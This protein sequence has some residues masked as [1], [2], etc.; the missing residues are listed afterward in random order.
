LAPVE[1]IKL[2]RGGIGRRPLDRGRARPGL[3]LFAPQNGGGNAYPIDLDGK[4]LPARHMP[5][6]PGR[7]GCLAGRGALF[8]ENSALITGH[9]AASFKT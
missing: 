8:L 6:P 5:W 2:K 4:I 1:P 7:D 3:P 9:A